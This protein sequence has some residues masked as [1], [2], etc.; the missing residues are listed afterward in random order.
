RQPVRPVASA[1]SSAP[2]TT[3]ADALARDPAR[4]WRSAP[5]DAEPWLLLDFGRAR[6]YGG[7]VVDWDPLDYGT[8]YRVSTSD[9]GT[10]FEVVYEAE[11]AD[12]GRDWIYLPDTESRYVRLEML[13]ASRGRGF[14]AQ[15]LGVVPT[16]LAESPNRFLAAVAREAPRGHFPRYLLDEAAPW[17]V[18]GADGDEAEGLLGADGALE[19]ARESFSI[20]PFLLLD[21]RLV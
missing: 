2:G 12:G 14:A 17:T 20:E 6:E 10:T 5:G 9:D 1:S 13:T 8:A 19:V 11:A 21:G 3:A 18:L 16:A 15:Y 4:V 7:V